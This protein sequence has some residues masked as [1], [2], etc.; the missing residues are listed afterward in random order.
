MTKP[1]KPEL[2]ADTARTLFHAHGFAA[3]T[4]DKI[5]RAA[6]VSRPTFYKYYAD[7]NALIRRVFTRQKEQVRQTLQ[8]LAQSGGTL[9][10][11][12]E[13][14]HDLQQQSL[15]ELYSEAVLR[16]IPAAVDLELIAFFRE[17]E[18]EK[19]RFMRGFFHTLQQ[20]KLIHRSLPPEL[21]DLFIRQMDSLMRQPCLAELYA[22]SP[23]RLPQDILQLLLYGLTSR[24]AE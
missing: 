5:C 20:R 23:Q 18:E 12:L 11:I 19:Y 9:A 14:F 16:D 2:L 4:V 7:K 17:M 10:A 15:S 3:V 13:G 22:P 21:I 8:E 1:S 6:A 24:E